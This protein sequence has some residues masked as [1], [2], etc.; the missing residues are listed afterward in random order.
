MFFNC[1]LRVSNY[2]LRITTLQKYIFSAEQPKV[3]PKTFGRVANCSY[4]CTV[5]SCAGQMLEGICRSASRRVTLGLSKNPRCLP[6]NV[7][8]GVGGDL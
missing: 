7:G 8:A 4:F 6:A 5:V 2:E 3:F 1:G